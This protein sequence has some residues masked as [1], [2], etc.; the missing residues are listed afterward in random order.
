MLKQVIIRNIIKTALMLFFITCISLFFL[1]SLDPH[2]RI[3]QYTTRLWTTADG[4]PQ[5][6]VIS[7]L[8]TSDGYLWFGCQE[9]LARFDGVKF[10]VFRK[11]ITPG[12]ESEYMITLHEDAAKNLWMGTRGGLTRYN[13][14]TKTFKT[15][16]REDGLW[17]NIVRAVF[18]DSKGALW[19]GTLKGLNRKKGD[20]IEKVSRFPG[21]QVRTI[22]EDRSRNLWFGTDQG[23]ARLKNPGDEFTFFTT[24]HGL[25]ANTVQAILED[26]EGNLWVATYS[27]KGLARFANETFT[28]ISQA[29]GLSSNNLTALC[30]DRDGNL[31]IGTEGSG[32]NRISGEDSGDITGLHSKNSLINDYVGA[33]YEDREGSL[34][35]GTENG[36]SQMRN[37]KLITWTTAEGLSDNFISCVF[38]DSQQRLWIGTYAGRLNVLH[39]NRIIPFSGLKVKG[40]IPLKVFSICEDHADTLWFGTRGNGLIRLKGSVLTTFTTKNGLSHNSIW[41]IHEDRNRDLWI[42]TK[43]GLN[44]FEKGKFRIFT[45]S[46]G[47]T[48]E[49]IYA[50]ISDSRRNLWIGTS[51]GGLNVFKN[52]TFKAYTTNDGLSDNIILCIYEDAEGILWIGTSYGLNRFKDGVFTSYTTKNGLFNNV[53]FQILEDNSGYLWMSSNRGISRVKKEQLNRLAEGKVDR[54]QSLGYGLSAGMRS[55]ECNGGFQPAGWKRSDGMLFFPTTGGLAMILPGKSKGRF[56]R[57]PPPVVVEQL[58]VKGKQKPITPSETIEIGPGVDKLEFHYTALSFISPRDVRFKFKLEGYDNQWEQVKTPRDRIAYYSH[59]PPGDYTFQVTA[60]N[61]DGVWNETGAAVQIHILPFF[62]ETWWFRFLAVLVFAAISYAIINLI[63][64]YINIFNFW[65]QKN[66]IGNYKIIDKIG[67]GGMGQ[68]YLAQHTS[69]PSRKVALKVLK[70][71]Y[72]VDSVQIKRFKQEALVIDQIEHAN[73]IKIFERGEHGQN[74]YIAMEWLP[75]KTLGKR[76][77]EEQPLSISDCVHIMRQI[78]GALT[79]IHKKKIVHRDLKPDNIMLVEKNKDPL[80]VKLLDFGLAKAQTFSRLTETG[81]VIGTLSYLSPEQIKESVYSSASDIYSL[82]V[83]FYEM[84]TGIKP[85]FGETS[86]EIMKEILNK[87]PVEPVCLRDEVPEELSRLIMRM[88]EKEPQDRPGIKDV[89]SILEKIS[90]PHH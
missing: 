53:V 46:E 64:K 63:K 71:E 85:F 54:I 77:E 80:F 44:K 52:G 8:Q 75:G 4:L 69:E 19:I 90:I 36:V 9:G 29:D 40:T 43:K 14:R 61:N 84:L 20:T 87:D 23:L 28:V 88:M 56:K 65:K 72:V 33:I 26:R 5:N 34:W 67:T 25:P 13:D 58:V 11:G 62:W 7:I 27:G 76:L 82:G 3:T 86:L 66:Y 49:N 45:S 55:V 2:R 51:G 47:L 57:V 41:V 60:C 12:I 81:I 32:V 1:H 42:G 6:T 70:D 22:Y 73:I 18:M 10:T 17:D 30:P 31:W 74:I 89:C 24:D 15:F 16:T 50:I 83:T 21:I 37:G 38:E 39:N 35:I 78:A 68:V 59:L 48:N 79:V